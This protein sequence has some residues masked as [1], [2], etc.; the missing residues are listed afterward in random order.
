M[1][2]V[3]VRKPKPTKAKKSPK[4]VVDRQSMA[5]K[6]GTNLTPDKEVLKILHTLSEV[7]TLYKARRF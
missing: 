4:K 1:K 2:K 5:H 3:A 7:G 6:L